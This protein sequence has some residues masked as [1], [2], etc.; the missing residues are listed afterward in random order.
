LIIAVI[1]VTEADENNGFPRL[2]VRSPRELRRTGFATK[3]TRYYNNNKN[4]AR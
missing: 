3:N 4:N 2:T 1:A